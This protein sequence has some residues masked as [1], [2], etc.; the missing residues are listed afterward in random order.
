VAPTRTTVFQKAAMA[1]S[2]IILVLYLLAHMYGNIK[3]F[4]G[5]Q[6][7][8]DYS[9][10]LRELGEPLLPHTG[11]LWIIRVVLLLAI[12]VHM[13]AAV[14]LWRRAS[15][16]RTSQ[17]AT[18]GRR[19]HTKNNKRGVQRSYASFTLRW[20]GIIIV[21][22]VVYHLLH[23]TFNVAAPGGASE[24]PYQRT[25]NGF[26]VWWVVLAYTI[27]MIAVGFHLRHGIFSAT[28]TLGYNTTRRQLNLNRMATWLALIITVGFLIPPYSVLLG[29]VN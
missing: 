13:W 3:L 2:G 12:A 22:F 24:S 10:H 17:G 14:S 21:L 26:E 1:V 11:A 27:A 19:Y 15:K 18:G 6:A 5:Q 7:F 20:G 16:A 23:L 4:S 25:V 29:L 8:D 9:H 28:Q